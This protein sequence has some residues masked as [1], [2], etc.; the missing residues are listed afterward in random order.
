MAG[1]GHIVCGE[2]LRQPSRD[3]VPCATAGRDQLL[4]LKVHSEY[5]HREGIAVGPASGDRIRTFVA[6]IGREQERGGK[7]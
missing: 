4:D 1:T 2:N 6:A 5:L 3:L 7:E